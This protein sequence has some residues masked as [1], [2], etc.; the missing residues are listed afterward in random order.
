M[1]KHV[2][3]KWAASIVWFDVHGNERKPDDILGS[4]RHFG[5]QK[6]SVA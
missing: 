6:S 1:D 3:M 2:K 5:M 4:W